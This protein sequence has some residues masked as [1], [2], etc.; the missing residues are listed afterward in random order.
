M[1]GQLVFSKDISV[2]IIETML[3]S[4]LR[5]SF[6][7]SIEEHYFQDQSQSSGIHIQYEYTEH[8]FQDPIPKKNIQG[9]F[10]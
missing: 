1:D 2:T 6:L 3:M 8:C 10:Y 7:G 5:A 4:N 9:L